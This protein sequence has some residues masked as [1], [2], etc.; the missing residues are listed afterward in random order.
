METTEKLGNKPELEDAYKAWEEKRNSESTARS[1]WQ[2]IEDLPYFTLRNTDQKKLIGM[3]N[4]KVTKSRQK[5]AV[6]AFIKFLY[7]EWEKNDVT[8]EEYTD[9]QLKKNAVTSNIEISEKNKQNNDGANPREHWM[10]KGELVDLLRMVEPRRAKLYY[11]LYAGGFRM[12]E[13]ERLTPAHLRGDYGE[14]GAAKVLEDRS[15]SEFNRMVKF[16]TETPLKIFNSLDTGTWESDENGESWENVFFWDMS[17]SNE[18][19]YLGPRKYAGEL[20]LGQ[21]S[22]HSFRHIRTTDLAKASNIS[23]DDLRRRHGWN[24]GSDVIQNY[25]EFVPDS[26]PQTLESYCEEKGIDIL[27]VINSEE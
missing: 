21:R 12:G 5:T 20:G 25:L 14:N 27:E 3:L 26:H 4:K 6:N 18:Y 2:R 8:D 7:Q 22:S 1:Y 19:Y 11:L 13:I 16:R 15:K 10:Y 9:L 23:D 24:P 17:K